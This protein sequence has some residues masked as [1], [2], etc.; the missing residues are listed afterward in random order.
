MNELTT[1]S[2]LVDSIAG[3][4]NESLSML[5]RYL[6]RL[7]RKDWCWHFML[8]SPSGESL[9]LWEVRSIGQIRCTLRMCITQFCWDFWFPGW[10]YPIRR[11]NLIL[12]WCQ[13]NVFLPL[14]VSQTHWIPKIWPFCDS[15]YSALTANSQQ[16]W[17]LCRSFNVAIQYW[18]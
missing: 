8:A 1:W 17:Q 5:K 9:D 11:R 13:R 10:P 18:R 3:R 12:N 4:I 2:G 16:I 15:E 6:P 7:W 14:C